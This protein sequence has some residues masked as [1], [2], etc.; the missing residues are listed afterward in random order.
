MNDLIIKDWKELEDM[1]TDEQKAQAEADF[2]RIYPEGT[3]EIICVSQ[4]PE[5][6]DY[7]R[8]VDLKDFE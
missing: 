6:E 2:R 5:R 1:M 7:L 3:P 8:P 4:V